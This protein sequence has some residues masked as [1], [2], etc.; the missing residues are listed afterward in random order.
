M[1]KSVAELPTKMWPVVPV[2]PEGVEYTPCQ[3]V[4]VS[5]FA[6]VQLTPLLEAKFNVWELEASRLMIELSVSFS[7][8]NETDTAL[9]IPPVPNVPPFIVTLDEVKFSFALGLY[10]S[11][12]PL[13]TVSPV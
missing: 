5:V 11:S 10:R 1:V 2:V 13:I 9:V 7:V 8:E 6:A 3:P 12:P 4:M